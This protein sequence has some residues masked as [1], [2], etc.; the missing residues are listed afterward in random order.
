MILNGILALASRYDARCKGVS[1]LESAHYSSLCIAQL[2]GALARP[3]E[4]WD[5]GLLAAVVIARLYEE[6]E[7]ETDSYR[8]HLSGTRNL[9]NHEVIYRF[10]MQ[11]G[12]AEAA[13]FVHLRQSIYVFLATR[14][15]VEI[16]L[17]NFEA[18]R[19]FIRL[20]DSSF[21]NRTVYLFAKVLTHFFD[22]SPRKD[23]G[24]KG[25]GFWESLE[26]EADEWYYSKPLSFN[27]FNFC[28][29]SKTMGNLTV[30][31]G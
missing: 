23:A 2:R 26:Q 7:V 14:A 17:A 13:S 20:D 9:L 22:P 28:S 30:E 19:I 3:A 5:S 31:A 11:G 21:A 10:V 12:L 16:D 15:P 27:S 29:A 25:V 6:Y 8:H 18:S 1:D 4:L 24:N